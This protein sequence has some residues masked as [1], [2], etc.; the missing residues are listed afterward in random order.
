MSVS[1]AGGKPPPYIGELKK[2]QSELKADKNGLENRELQV[3]NKKDSRV[4]LVKSFSSI[5]SNKKLSERG[6]AT[7][8]KGA[9]SAAGKEGTKTR[10][11]ATALKKLKQFGALIKN[12][13]IFNRGGASKA[14][15]TDNTDG[16]SGI[17]HFP[18]DQFKNV[19][20]QY[21]NIQAMR[22]DQLELQKQKELA[23][24]EELGGD[25][26]GTFNE[27]KDLLEEI[28]NPPQKESEPKEAYDIEGAER[29]YLELLL[30]EAELGITDELIEAD[31]AFLEKIGNAGK[32]SLE[33]INEKKAKE[34]S[35]DELLDDVEKAIE[36]CEVAFKELE[37]TL[38]LLKPND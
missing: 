18:F 33:Q 22:K 23:Y 26:E 34:A 15:K 16:A 12:I 37:A 17:Q 25:A 11:A 5:S 13:Q 36:K 2:V 19:G 7:A 32:E 35:A 4:S 8:V 27:L 20:E 6:V 38:E 30:L 1:G 21:D 3:A 31:K 24:L 29:S 14:Q 9:N 28:V 10:R